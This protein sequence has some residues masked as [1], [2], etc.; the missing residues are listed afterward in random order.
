VLKATKQ[1]AAMAESNAQTAAATVVTPRKK[2][3]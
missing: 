2:T 1:M 3:A